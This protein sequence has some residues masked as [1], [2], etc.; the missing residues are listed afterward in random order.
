MWYKVD[1]HSRLDGSYVKE[2]DH[3]HALLCKSCCNLADVF[4]KVPVDTPLEF[5]SGTSI[6]RKKLDD[7]DCSYR[8][9]IKPHI[10]ED[11]S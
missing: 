8:R 5:R 3:M 9:D 10:D 11:H 1:S 6:R 4:H 2:G 7:N